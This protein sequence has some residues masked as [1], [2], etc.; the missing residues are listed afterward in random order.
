MK[1]IE[2]ERIF[3][4]VICNKEEYILKKEHGKKISVVYCSNP[5]CLKNKRKMEEVIR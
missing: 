2:K 3:K 5:P 4:C 1:Q